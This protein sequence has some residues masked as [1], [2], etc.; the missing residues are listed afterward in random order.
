LIERNLALGAFWW[1]SGVMPRLHLAPLRELTAQIVSGEYAVAERLES[2]HE[3]GERFGVGRSVVREVMRG[4]EERGLVEVRHGAGAFVAPQADW[5]AL[6]AEVLHA[7]LRAP[8]RDRLVGE[9]ITLQQLLEGWAVELAAERMDV[10]AGAA[11]AAALDE[12]VRSAD[13][14]LIGVFRPALLR[15]H[16]ALVRASGVLPLAVQAT[17]VAAGLVSLDGPETL[18]SLTVVVDAVLRGNAH[19]A[20][21]RLGDHLVALGARV[22]MVNN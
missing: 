9:L 22:A 21:R 16:V 18:P 2:E 15:V 14:S 12:A 20:R 7:L 4:L 13:E 17:D 10:A 8:G 11:L 6:D 5:R 19:E 1:L 3:L